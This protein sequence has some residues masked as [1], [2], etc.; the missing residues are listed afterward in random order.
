MVPLSE[1]IAG[2][3]RNQFD[4][5][6]ALEREVRLEMEAAAKLAKSFIGQE[7][8][9]WDPLKSSTIAEKERGGYA[10]PAPLKRTGEL[11]ES[12][13]GEAESTTN[14][15][16]GM[17]YS[18]DPTA[19]WHEFGTSRLPARPFLGPALVLSETAIGV[20]LGALAIRTLTPGKRP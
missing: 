6:F 12:I 13:K 7:M 16:R 9:G 17:V 5:K 4:L 8:P 19:L 18:E 14:G 3:K 2:L 10:T 15:V 1:Y 11:A 20:A